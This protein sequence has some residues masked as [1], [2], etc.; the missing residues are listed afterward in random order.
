MKNLEEEYPQE[1]A[2]KGLSYTITKYL[3]VDNGQLDEYCI[4][5]LNNSL[6]PW[7]FDYLNF[8]DGWEKIL[9]H[10]LNLPVPF[11]LGDI[12]LAD[13]RP[14]ARLRRVLI[15]DV[16]DNIDCCCLRALYIG[17]DDQMFEGAFKHNDFLFNSDGF[18]PI[19]G[20]YRAYR[21]TG[22][23]ADC[24]EPFDMLSPLIYKRPGLG[25]EIRDYIWEKGI[26]GR[27]WTEVKGFFLC[28]CHQNLNAEKK[29][30]QG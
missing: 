25:I 15:L 17:E 12:V 22:K 20:L 18:S 5:Y 1:S 9:Y 28:C 2:F 14:Y 11:Q 30:K 19:S 4:W 29:I 26:D 21:W 23:P 24:E 27:P 7:Y 10:D 8:S 3:P 6:E 16:G 13:C